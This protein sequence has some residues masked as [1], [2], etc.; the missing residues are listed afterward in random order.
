MKYS[1][2]HTIDYPQVSDK[3]WERNWESDLPCP[4]CQEEIN[5][6]AEEVSDVMDKGYTSNQALENFA[7][8]IGVTYQELM[9]HAKEY[10]E[11]GETWNEGPKFDGVDTPDD[12]WENYSKVTRTEANPEWKGFFSC[13][14]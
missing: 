12:F 7:N 1:C 4:G 6:K 11:T 5:R 8:E 10:L 14:C 2:G 13:S 3:E 9:E